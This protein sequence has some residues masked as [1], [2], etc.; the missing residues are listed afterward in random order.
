VSPRDIEGSYMPCFLSGLSVASGISYS[1]K[2]PLHKFSHQRGH[3]AAALYSANKLELFNTPFIAFHVSGG[4]TDAVI[5]TPDKDLV[6]KCTTARETLDLNAGQV[7]DR[8]GVMLGLKFPAGAELEKLAIKGVSPKK[9][10]AVLKNGCP[11]L[12]GVENQCANMLRSGEKKE[13]IARYA[14]DFIAQT[15]KLMAKDLIGEYGNLPMVFAGG[16]MSD[17]IIKNELQNEFRCVFASAEYSC[18]NAVGI[19]VLTAIKEGYL[20]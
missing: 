19:A 9:I 5:V 8:V 16:V 4:T 1:Q 11:C 6:I 14:I 17:K 13:N 3:I 20:I 7:I 2:I 12:S 18:D 15:I 10:K